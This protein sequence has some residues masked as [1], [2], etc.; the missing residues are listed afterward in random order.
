MGE[1]L[2]AEP[3]DINTL[4]GPLPAS[5]TDL[6]VDELGVL[7][8]KHGVGACCTMSTVGMLLDHTSG[9]AATLAA[10]RET[11]SLIPVGTVNPLCYFGGEGP[12]QQFVDDGFRLIRFFPAQQ[13]WPLRFAPFRT[14]L[15][16]LTD[17]HLPVMVNVSCPGDATELADLTQGLSCRMILAGVDDRQVAEAIAVLRAHAGFY[18]ETSGLAAAGA[19]KLLVAGVGPERVLF[20]SAAPAQPMGSALAAVRRSGVSEADH[21]AIL[22][23]NAR[24]LLG[25]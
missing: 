23:D 20:G 25:I 6:P 19:V 9:N 2:M 11:S 1:R 17:R 24:A 22:G 4:F 16:T 14:L 15:R 21:A 10:C 3:L 18:A 12:A 13:G 7:M 5:S 8:Q